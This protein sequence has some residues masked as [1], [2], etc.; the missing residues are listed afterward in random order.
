MTAEDKAPVEKTDSEKAEAEMSP[1][2]YDEGNPLT[3]EEPAVKIT[4]NETKI[5]IGK[6]EKGQYESLSKEAVRSGR[7]LCWKQKP[8]MHMFQKLAEYQAFEL[9]HP[10]RYLQ[11]YPHSH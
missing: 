4:A 10:A 9:G 6:D 8:K 1:P 3:S 2:A 11:S 7:P 5:D